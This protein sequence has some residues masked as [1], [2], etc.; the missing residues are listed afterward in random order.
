MAYSEA[1]CSI[2]AKIPSRWSPSPPERVRP[3]GRGS[4]SI[5]TYSSC[6]TSRQKTASFRLLGGCVLQWKRN[7]FQKAALLASTCR[8]RLKLPPNCYKVRS[9]ATLRNPN[10]PIA[11]FALRGRLPLHRTPRP[12]HPRRGLRALGRTRGL[13]RLG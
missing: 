9:P 6:I 8:L 2:S 7:S 4:L 12:R 5:K 10:I 11:E 13:S 3:A 1:I